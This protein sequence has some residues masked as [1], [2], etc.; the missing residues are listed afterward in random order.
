M[1]LLTPLASKDIRA[2]FSFGGVPDITKLTKNGQYGKEPF[3]YNSKNENYI[4]FATNYV[5]NINCPIFYF[6]G[7]QDYYSGIS[8]INM[9]LK[10]QEKARGENK[11]FFAYPIKG[12][13]HHHHLIPLMN[14]VTDKI[15]KD[16]KPTVSI[17][18]T[19]NEVQRY[20]NRFVEN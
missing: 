1:A 17:S 7:T 6:E 16:N 3:D 8:F 12:S 2:S 13:D 19:Q 5:K 14:L 4:R 18:F 9:A 10:M 15:L 20:Y 11:P